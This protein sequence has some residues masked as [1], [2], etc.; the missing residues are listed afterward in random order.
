MF[1]FCCGTVIRLLLVVHVYGLLLV[2]D[3]FVVLLVKSLL[4]FSTA[5]TFFFGGLRVKLF[6]IL[7]PCPPI[8]TPNFAFDSCLFWKLIKLLVLILKKLSL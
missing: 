5:V 4:I 6:W 7:L 1:M 3:I 8:A 2:K